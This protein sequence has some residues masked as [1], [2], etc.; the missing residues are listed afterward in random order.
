MKRRL[1]FWGGLG[2]ALGLGIAFA[3]PATRYPILGFLGDETLY[4]GRPTRYWIAA[5]KEDKPEGRRRAALNL[6][7][8]GVGKDSAPDDPECRR[9][10][11]A[12]VEAL[13]DSDGFVRK[14]AATSFLMYPKEAPVPQDRSSVESLTGA[15]GDD[16]VAVRRAAARALWQAGAA[17]KEADG[18][19]RLTKAVEDKDDFVRAYACRALARIGPDAEAAVP[20]LLVRLRQD[21]ERDVRKLAAK[22]LGLIGAKAIGPLL[23]ET[24]QA[25]TDALKEEPAGLREYAARSLGQLGDK[26][27][28]PALRKAARDPNGQVRASAAEALK[29][30]ESTAAEKAP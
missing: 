16:E 10:V 28:L 4:D 30:L 18:V 12:L 1:V 6:G 21:E 20:T 9:V 26:S 17:A 8:V 5:L 3:L 23:S 24:V 29:L 7:D 15:L 22:T 14:C 2:L 11:A 19:A 27:A 25:L 13:G